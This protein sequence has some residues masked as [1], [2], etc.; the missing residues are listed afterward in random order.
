M[1]VTMQPGMD[2]CSPDE[3]PL[4]KYCYETHPSGYVVYE[5]YLPCMNSWILLPGFE[6]MPKGFLAAVYFAFLMYL[7]LGISILSDVFMG[8]IEVITSAKR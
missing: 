4:T 3:A 1:N 7:F 6:L 8:S 5:D 2:K